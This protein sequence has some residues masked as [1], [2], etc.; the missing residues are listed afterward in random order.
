MQ[1]NGADVL[2]DEIPQEL[3]PK[4]LARY[5]VNRSLLRLTGSANF[6]FFLILNTSS[7]LFKGNAHLRRA[8]NYAVDRPSLVRASGFLVGRRT[9]QLLPPGMPGFHNAEPVP[10]QGP[11]PQDGTAAGGR[12]PARPKGRLLRNS[13]PLDTDDRRATC[14][15]S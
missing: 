7:P 13:D 11:R 14:A 12:A 1:K 8:I 3:R 6:A 9:D 10:T 2:F 15:T 5:G 4:L